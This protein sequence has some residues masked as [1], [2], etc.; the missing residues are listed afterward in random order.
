MQEPAPENFIS[1]QLLTNNVSMKL[2]DG[3]GPNK[4]QKELRGG[5][6]TLAGQRG[7]VDFD[8]WMEQGGKSGACWEILGPGQQ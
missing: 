3:R 2:E 6:R 4:L 1:Y 5:E 7:G 8:E